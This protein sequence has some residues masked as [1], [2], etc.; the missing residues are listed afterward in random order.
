MTRNPLPLQFWLFGQDARWG[1]LE[2]WG[3][4]QVEGRL[5]R[6]GDWWLHP[7]GLKLEGL[8]YSRAEKS[9]FEVAP[10]CIPPILDPA[11]RRISYHRAWPRMSEHLHAYENWVQAQQPDYRP[12]LL[13]ICPPL[14]RP[15]RHH[16]CREF[17]QR[18]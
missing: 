10:D 15:S 8:L 1:F 12:R 18:T 6:K 13:R 9:F 16:W 14:L 3:F 2:K 4:S 11:A 5:Y 7:L 17:L